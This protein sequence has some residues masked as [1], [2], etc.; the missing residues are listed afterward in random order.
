MTKDYAKEDEEFYRQRAV[1]YKKEGIPAHITLKNG[2]WRRGVILEITDSYLVL[3]EFILG[4]ETIFFN[5]I[6]A[7]EPKREQVRP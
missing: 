6:Y 7:L 3:E 5:E 1:N 4:K 2:W